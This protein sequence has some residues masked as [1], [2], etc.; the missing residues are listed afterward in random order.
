MAHLVKRL[1]DFVPKSYEDDQLTD[2]LT[3]IHVINCFD[4]NQLLGFLYQLRD[5]MQVSACLVCVL[6]VDALIR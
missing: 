1:M 2:L 3:R 4:H 6:I 5:D